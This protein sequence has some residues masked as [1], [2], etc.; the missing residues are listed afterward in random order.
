MARRRGKLL[1]KYIIINIVVWSI[2]IIWTLPF[3]GVAMTSVKPFSEV[4]VHGWWSFIGNY[5]LK[6][7]IDAWSNPMY[8]VAIGYRNS[9]IVTIPATIAPLFIAALAAYVFSRFSFPLKT[10]LFIVLLVIMAMPQQMSVIPLFFMLNSMGLYDKLQG[11]ILVHTAWGLAW[12]TFFLK[13]F[14]DALPR[15]IEEA[16]RVDG[17]GDAQIFFKIVLPMSMPAIASVAAI[18]FTWVWS[19]F[20]YALM[21]LVNPDNYVVTLQVASM[22]G[23]YH[24][25]WGLLSAGSIMAMSVPLLL[26][27]LLQKYYVRGMVGW[28][29]K[30]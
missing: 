27:A 8:S 2:A 30:G 16:A 23:Q 13:N 28:T 5:T 3:I 15:E 29:L 1:L 7:F 6:N 26:Y 25:D 11:L 17:A 10:L 21:F 12:M 20:F 19:D 22:K 14:F 9:F 24:I 4:V 18:Q